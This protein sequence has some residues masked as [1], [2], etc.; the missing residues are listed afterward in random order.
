VDEDG[1]RG[2]PMANEDIVVTGTAR[3][4]SVAAE[5]F[6]S[7][8]IERHDLTPE[9]AIVKVRPDRAPFPAF[10]P[11][12]YTLLGL[13]P[14]DGPAV[15]P[16]GRTRMNRRAYSIASSADQR[17]HLEFYVVLI[18]GGK[19]ST[20]L[21]TVKENG[22]L[23]LDTAVRGSFTLGHIEAGSDLLLAATGTG[24][25]PFMSMLRTYRDTGLWR[26]CVLVHGVRRVAD[27][28][29]RRELEKLAEEDPGFLYVPIVSRAGAEH[30]PGLRGRVQIA[31][32]P[33]AFER[34]TGDSLDPERYHAYLC[35]NPDMVESA[36]EILETRGFR[37]GHREGP[38]GIHYEKYW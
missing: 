27:L 31:F 1:A 30:W 2:E 18:E 29:Y 14:A 35:G 21:W 3:T 17:D 28:G 13:P 16:S 33:R 34:L 26:R 20:V 5:L 11:G 37:F 32:E 25:A 6:N 15:T 19:L 23:W 4:A 36:R 8:L 38:G 7:T 22:R 9:L 24:I 12:Q 10:E